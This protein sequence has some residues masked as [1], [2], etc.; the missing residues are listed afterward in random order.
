MPLQPYF[1]LVLLKGALN[2]LKFASVN[3][4]PLS[5]IEMF[6]IGKTLLSNSSPSTGWAVLR[7][8]KTSILPLSLFDLI[9]LIH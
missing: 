6:F 5:T 9:K 2:D 4:S 8:M 1:L 7:S 3:P